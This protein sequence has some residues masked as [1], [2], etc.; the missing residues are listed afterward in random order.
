MEGWTGLVFWVLIMVVMRRV[1]VQRTMVIRVEGMNDNGIEREVSG[2]QDNI[3]QSEEDRTAGRMRSS[4]D[5]EQEVR[6]NQAINDHSELR[7]DFFCIQQRY[8]DKLHA[9]TCRFEQEVLWPPW[10]WG[11]E[12]RKSLA[13][14]VPRFSRRAKL[15]EAT[16]RPVCSSCRMN[17]LAC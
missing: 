1:I 8:K 17:Q 6:L 9:L 11:L 3:F 12:G 13:T 15:A 5:G 16:C 14:R 2:C 4:L 7:L 10:W